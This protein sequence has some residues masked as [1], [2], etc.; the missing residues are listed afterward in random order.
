MF[1]GTS[2]LHLDSKGRCMLPKRYRPILSNEYKSNLLV[3]RDPYDACLL[4]YPIDEWL[5]IENNLIKLPNLDSANRK[6][7]RMLVGHAQELD[8]DKNGRILIPSALREFA[9]IDSS[10]VLVGQMKKFEVWS[11]ESWEETEK[12]LYDNSSESGNLID[13]LSL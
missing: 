9:K 2:E 5:K 7:L 8:M 12:K 13:M 11:R 10:L 3:T 6:I 1:R 4:L